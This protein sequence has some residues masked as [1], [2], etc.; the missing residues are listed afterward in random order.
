MVRRG[1]LGGISEMP[2]LPIWGQ[3]VSGMY[4]CKHVCN[5]KYSRHPRDSSFSHPYP[6]KRGSVHHIFHHVIKI[7]QFFTTGRLPDVNPP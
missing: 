7:W 3:S 5:N 6:T 2:L 1:S 4:V